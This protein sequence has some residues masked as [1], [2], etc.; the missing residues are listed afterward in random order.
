[1]TIQI[2]NYQFDGAFPDTTHLRNSSGVYIVL[3]NSGKVIDVGES[4][5]VKTRL[6]N[7]DRKECWQQYGNV[8]FAV[9]Y[10]NE[11]ARMRIEKEIRNVSNPPCGER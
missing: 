7:H 6:E 2:L 3:D 10:T 11:N 1:M 9:Y 5:T 4:A 8:K